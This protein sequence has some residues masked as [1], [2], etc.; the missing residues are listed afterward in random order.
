METRRFWEVDGEEVYY[1]VAPTLGDMLAVV[2]A[3]SERLGDPAEILITEL[4]DEQA[5]EAMVRSVEDGGEESLIGAPSMVLL[6][7]R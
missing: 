1:V 2:G 3:A 5:I 4:T 7:G 6:E